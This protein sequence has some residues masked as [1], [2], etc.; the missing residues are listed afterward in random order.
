[1]L[2]F[3]PMLGCH[4]GACRRDDTTLGDC[5]VLCGLDFITDSLLGGASTR[6]ALGPIEGVQ[7]PGQRLCR[8]TEQ[9]RRHEGRPSAATQL[10]R[11]RDDVARFGSHTWA[12]AHGGKF[13]RRKAPHVES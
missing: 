8:F 4:G 13:G 10:G 9:S 11:R 3:A 1:M 2:R 7:L 12:N 5:A 6:G